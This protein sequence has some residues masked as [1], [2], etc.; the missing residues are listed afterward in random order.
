MKVGVIGLGSMGSAIAANLISA[1]HTV[2]VYNRTPSKTELLIG[3][4]AILAKMATEA[5][6]GDIVITMLSDDEAL[7]QVVFGSGSKGDSKNDHFLA[8]QGAETIHVSMG[9]VSV[10]LVRQ[11]SE[12]SATLGKK[13]ISATVMGRP[14]VAQKGEL[15]V[16][17]AGDSTLVERCQPMFAAIGKSHHLIGSRPEQANLFKL[18]CNFMLSSM[19]E[20]FAESF[21]LLRKN[22]IDHYKLLEIMADEFFQSP[23]Y[24]KYG[25]IIADG[26]FHTG[27]FT[28]SGQEKDTRLA[29]EAAIESK[30][31]MPLCSAIENAFLSAIGRGKGNLDPC[32]LAEIAAE[33]A[34]VKP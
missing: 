26:Q 14:E 8:K 6:A 13:F 24:R 7:R 28:V 34:G 30:V 22:N 17:A 29:L 25:K 33:N 3:Q 1:G 23:L 9:T 32:A 15:I 27:A 31:P 5:A 16:M 19:I 18:T 2:T 21:A 4:G 12:E 10:K 11:I 20:T